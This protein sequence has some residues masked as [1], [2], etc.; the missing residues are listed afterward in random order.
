MRD[1]LVPAHFG[2]VHQ[3]FDALLELDENAIVHDADDFAVDFAAGRIF[4]RVVHPR[5]GRQ[6]LKSERDALLFLVELED[7]DVALLLRLYYVG[8]MLAAAPTTVLDG[9][10]AGYS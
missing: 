6:L 4:F 9:K 5:I 1:L 7:D 10:Q 3:A 2:N 8:G